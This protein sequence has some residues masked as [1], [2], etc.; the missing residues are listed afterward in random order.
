MVRSLV[1]N[2]NYIGIATND[3]WWYKVAV[4]LFKNYLGLGSMN[5][6]WSI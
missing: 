2:T 3:L 5:V 6:N 1:G 4:Y